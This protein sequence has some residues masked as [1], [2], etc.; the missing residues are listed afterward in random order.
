MD[1]PSARHV[2]LCF[3]REYYQR[4][5]KDPTKLRQLYNEAAEFTFAEGDEDITPVKG[6]EAIAAEI[7]RIGFTN[8]RIDLNAGSVDCQQ[9]HDGGVMVMVCGLLTLSGQEPKQFVQSFFLARVPPNSYVVRNS[10]LRLIGSAPTASEPAAPPAAPVIEQKPAVPQKVAEAPAESAPSQ[11]A[12]NAVDSAEAIKEEPKVEQ[13]AAAVTQ[14][15]PEPAPEAAKTDATAKAPAPAKSA[16]APPVW[17]GNSNKFLFKDG[18]TTAAAPVPK[19]VSKPQPRKAAEATDISATTENKATSLYVKGA[20]EG[21]DAVQ[22]RKLFE[23]FGNIQNVNL[24]MGYAF[25]DYD[26]FDAVTKALDH[27]RKTP[28]KFNDK[29]LEVE[30][31]Q[32]SKSNN[33]SNFANGAAGGRA[34]QRNNNRGRGNPNRKGDRK[35]NKTDGRPRRE[36]DNNRR[37]RGVRRNNDSSGHN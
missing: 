21:C 2:G 20:L 10:T 9:S 26:K 17:G 8:A 12:D 27:H 5:E 13:K 15:A 6:L 31:R 16:I 14:S 22:L 1:G 25:V 33:R 18:E 24:K 11:A 4:L 3:I 7:E 34:N 35:D 28:L 23:P 36:G 37:E 19:P 29:T 32:Q 30:L